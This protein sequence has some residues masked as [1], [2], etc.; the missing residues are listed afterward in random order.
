LGLL[1]GYVDQEIPTARVGLNE[2]LECIP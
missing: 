1:L 2:I